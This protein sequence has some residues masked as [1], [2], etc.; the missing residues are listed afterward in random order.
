MLITKK[1]IYKK[2]GKQWKIDDIIDS[3]IVNILL[4]DD[5]I[6]KH[7]F[8]SNMIKSIRYKYGKI[9]VNYGNNTKAVYE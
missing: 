8:K 5:M 6:A 7:L 1:T 2:D 9:Y 4:N 3:N